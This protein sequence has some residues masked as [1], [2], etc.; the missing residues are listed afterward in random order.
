[1][2]AAEPL[3]QAAISDIDASASAPTST[4]D[5]A[6]WRNRGKYQESGRMTA[7]TLTPPASRP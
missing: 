7:S 3:R 2:S 1:M 6:M 4:I 5:P